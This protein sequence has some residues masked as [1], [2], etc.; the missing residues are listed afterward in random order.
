MNYLKDLN[1]FSP[2]I[3]SKKLS[4]NKI[5]LTGAIIGGLVIVMVGLFIWNNSKINKLN[6][7]IASMEKFINNENTLKQL[8]EI[9]EIKSKLSIMKDYHGRLIKINDKYD[10]IDLINT[11]LINTISDAIPIKASIEV[12]N[13]ATDNIQMQG[14]SDSRVSI[15]EFEHNLKETN[16]FQ[17]VHVSDIS[18][19][20]EEDVYYMYIINCNF[21]DVLEDEVK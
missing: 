14:I 1:F 6:E 17:T 19:Q 9:K 2:Y 21:K 10:S 20:S 12:L 5:A 11:K 15:A 18:E 3:K 7:E 8:A 13:I 16:L 4:F